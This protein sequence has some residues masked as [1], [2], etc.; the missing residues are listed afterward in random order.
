MF[1][2]VYLHFCLS[3]FVV[4]PACNLRT[5][6][7]TNACR[8]HTLHTC[9]FWPIALTNVRV[10]VVLRVRFARFLFTFKAGGMRSTCLHGSYLTTKHNEIEKYENS[11]RFIENFTWFLFILIF[12]YEAIR[13]LFNLQKNKLHNFNLLR[14]KNRTQKHENSLVA[15]V[16]NWKLLKIA[17]KE[18]IRIIR[19]EIDCTNKQLLCD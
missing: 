17:R 9:P 8:A 16:N 3:C 18:T 7:A 1:L 12:H 14:C 19:V 15:S 5:L 6:L 2:F 13:I 4:G 11:C 10:F